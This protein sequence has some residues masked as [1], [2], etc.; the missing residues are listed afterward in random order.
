MEATTTNKALHGIR[1]YLE[2]REFEIVEKGW[3]H[4]RDRVD[5]VARA[6]GE[7]V[8][9]ACTVRENNREG[10]DAERN[11]RKSFERLAAAY[12][13][14]HTDEPE[15]IIRFDIVSMLV[16]ADHKALLRHHR[17]ALGVDSNDLR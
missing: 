16:L 11:D 3:A 12:L 17:N 10:F 1:T 14:E 6:D 7:L 2:R 8:F 9:I 5:F 13:V 4:G 15:S